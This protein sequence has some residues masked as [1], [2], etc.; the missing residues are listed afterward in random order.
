MVH[1][2]ASVVSAVLA[3]ALASSGMWSIVLLVVTKHYEASSEEKKKATAE[4]K[5]ILALAHDRVY[6]LCESILN[7]YKSGKIDHMEV[8][9]F[10]NLRILYEG[11]KD[12]GGNGTCKRLFTEACKIPVM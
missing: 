2:A 6:Y 12:M 9:E 7:D 1:E 8:D 11:Y 10:E 3:A 4:H 5:M